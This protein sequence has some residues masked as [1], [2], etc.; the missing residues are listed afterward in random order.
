MRTKQ[1]LL[2]GTMLVSTALWGCGSNAGSGGDQSAA[3]AGEPNSSIQN[4]QAV[5]MDVCTNCHAGQTN[6][7]MAGV[8]SNS[9]GDVASTGFPNT[10]FFGSTENSNGVACT[11]CHDQMGDSQNLTPLLTG[12]SARPIVS[13][14]SCHGGGGLHYG[15]GPIPYAAPDFDRCGQCHNSNFDHLSQHPESDSISENYMSSPHAGSI[16]Q[17]NYAEGSTTD[18]KALCSRCHTDEGVKLYKNLNGG[19]GDLSAALPDTVSPVENASVVQCRTCHN[20]HSP[21]DL[22]QSALL[23]ETDPLNPVTLESK[24]FRTCTT[25]HQPEDGFHGENSSRGINDARVIYDTHLGDDPTTASI[26]GYNIDPADSRSCRNCHNPHNADTTINK[27]WAKSGHGGRLKLY[28]DKVL[29]EAVNP[30]DVL[31]AG[32]PNYD[33]LANGD[34]VP[35]APAF[36]NPTY[37]YADDGRAACQRC[38]TATGAD[39]Y[40]QDPATYLTQIDDFISDP[41]NG[42]PN[43]YSYLDVFDADGNLV[44]QRREMLYCTSCHSDNSGGLEA[45]GAIVGTYQTVDR[46]NPAGPSI[47]ATFTDM[48]DSNVCIACHTGLTGGQDV[49]DANLDDSTGVVLRD[50]LDPASRVMFGEFNPHYRG[51]AAT[52]ERTMGYE[53]AGQNYDNLSFYGHINIGAADADGN[54]VVPGTGTSGSCVACH[55]N[56][57]NAAGVPNHRYQPYALDANDDISGIATVCTTCHNGAFELTVDFVASEK[58]GFEDAQHALEDLMAVDGIFYRHDLGWPYMYTRSQAQDEADPAGAIPND[59]GKFAFVFTGWDTVDSFGAVFNYSYLHTEPGAFAHNRHYTKKLL[60]DSIDWMDNKSLDGVID[61][62]A[63][64]EAAHWFGAADASAVLRPDEA[65]G[66]F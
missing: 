66:I 21:K 37:V 35:Y 4:A 58:H 47:P 60:F 32:A 38:H 22:L 40:M 45:P 43:D 64:P 19:P 3:A 18:V 56:D 36:A 8:H 57:S 28:K 42:N 7:W 20:A 65:A 62:S 15:T 31:T 46:A 48:G 33:H 24:E 52:M 10:A 39:N 13:C 26:E 14:E 30:A 27:Q 49:K 9:D 5:G 6:Q 12:N 53:F 54:E 25:C 41:A 63:R 23:D 34:E 2:L 29:A 44:G 1:V 16:N 59:G 50:P 17:Y 55:M 51:A 11:Q 61:L